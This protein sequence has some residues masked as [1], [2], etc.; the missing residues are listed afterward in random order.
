MT[1]LK[2]YA[3]LESGGLWRS[4]PDAQRRDVVVSF[5]N[6]T[7][8]ISD[9][10][11][12][13]LTHWSLPAVE[14]VN[15]GASP[16][17]FSP[18]PDGGETL[19]IADDTMVDA[20][21]KVRRAI[22]RQRP[23]PGRLRHVGLGLTLAAVLG[24]G[25]FWLP[26]AL[27]D[28]AVTVVPA[29]KRAEIGATLLG[30]VQR[31]TGPTCRSPLG[32]QALSRLH[33]RVTG[34]DAPGQIVVVPG[35]PDGAVALPGDIIVVNRSIIED[36]EDPAVVAGHVIAAQVRARATDPLREI[37]D[38]SGFGATLTLLTTGNM[39]PASLR[40]FAEELLAAPPDRPDDSALIAA[41]TEAKIPT[42]SYAYS[43]DVS[44]EQTLGLIEADPFSGDTVPVILDD[45][46]WISLQGI[47]GG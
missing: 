40:S 17:L 9:S 10:T 13:A 18:D 28:Q 21:E 7:L 31:L 25:V 23:K 15:P 47:C 16:A 2:E 45:G 34:P 6:A 42:T 30:H 24:L 14:R 11:G 46:S 37:L 38:R 3:R 36:T 1:A 8:V 19:E 12:R 39:S 33:D 32:N 44:G 22:A 5:G 20:I 4:D 41:F 29:T 35:G 26:G 27:I 43:V